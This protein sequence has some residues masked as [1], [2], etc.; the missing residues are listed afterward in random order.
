MN[1]LLERI[2]EYLNP[3]KIISSSLCE[4]QELLLSVKEEQIFLNNRKDV[5]CLLKKGGSLLL[6]FGKE[7]H[8][9]IKILTSR[10]ASNVR[11]RFGE[12]VAEA[13]AEL[14]ENNA[15]NAHS[16]RDMQ[17]FLPELSDQ[18]HGQ[19]GFRFVR[20]DNVGNVDLKLVAV[21]ASYHHLKVLPVGYF[22]CD[23]ARV[24]EIYSVAA[25][26][27]FLCMQNRLWDGIKRD[28]LVWIGDMHPET[29][30]I[31]C[32]YG[33][34]PLIELGLKETAE[35]C[36][37]EEWMNGIP[38][39][40]FWWLSILC[41]Y[42]FCCV[43][44]EFVLTQLPYA[45]KLVEK[46]SKCVSDSG[47]ISYSPSNNFFINW[48]T[49]DDPSLECANRGL[50]L[51]TMKKYVSMLKRYGKKSEVANLVID[52]LVKN[53]WFD[54]KS[55]AVAA[56]YALGY[57]VNAKVKAVLSSGGVM[58]FSTFMSYYI[59][60]AVKECLDGKT[61]LGLLKEFYG[62]MLDRGATSFWESYEPDWLINSGRIDA[63]PKEGEKDIHSSFGSN[64]YNGFRLSLCHGWSCGPVQFLTENALGIKFIEAGGKKIKI[65]PDL[66]GLK[67]VRGKVPTAYG[68]IEISHEQTEKGIKTEYKLPDGVTVVE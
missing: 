35:H 31:Y 23:D 18:E 28:R 48:E 61:A 2:K 19:T 24:N 60:Q 59:A 7:L 14:G 16:V 65:Q 12:S 40:S 13:C 42:D 55:K 37:I 57:G 11:I 9:G 63:L 22:E 46:I 33:D 54:G 27:L 26:T 58:G 43:K 4:N 1:S 6:D 10:S 20:I 66:M 41:D 49:V 52:K 29:T 36:P 44:R 34:H 32:L 38:S 45:E 39:Y 47:N 17:V 67:S 8:G 30:G 62:G 50:L 21:Y 53:D 3:V 15:C 56:I 68:V 51:W 25:R 5:F 64:C